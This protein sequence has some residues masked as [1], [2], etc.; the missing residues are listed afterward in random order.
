MIVVKSQG[1]VNNQI[2]LVTSNK[3]DTKNW[4]LKNMCRPKSRL[5][6]LLNTYQIDKGMLNQSS[7]PKTKSAYI[8]QSVVTIPNIIKH[9]VTSYLKAVLVCNS[10]SSPRTSRNAS[11]LSCNAPHSSRNT[12]Y[13]QGTEGFHNDSNTTVKET[14]SDRLK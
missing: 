5:L 13:H 8:H 9:I 3:D 6:F 14:S 1:I 10:R 4:H 7:A 11:H 12:R 2:L